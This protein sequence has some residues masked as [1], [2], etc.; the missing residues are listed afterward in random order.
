MRLF[1]VP[2]CLLS[3]TSSILQSILCLRTRRLQFAS[4]TSCRA[5]YLM[6]EMA[7]QYPEPICALLPVLAE[8]ATLHHYK[9]HFHLLETIWNQVRL[10]LNVVFG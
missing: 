10:S 9:H 6:R 8:V 1:F 3:C 4:L 7:A 5:V 2:G